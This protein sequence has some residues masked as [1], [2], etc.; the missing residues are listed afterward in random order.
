MG[1]EEK[2]QQRLLTENKG[3]GGADSGMNKYIYDVSKLIKD[4]SKLYQKAMVDLDKLRQD[5]EMED[6]LRRASTILATSFDKPYKDVYAKLE[7]MTGFFTRDSTAMENITTKIQQAFDT[8][9][10]NLEKAI[11]DLTNE[12][13]REMLKGFGV[14]YGR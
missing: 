7:D 14:I 3:S 4:R 6:F 11:E 9:K 8:E 10:Q 13:N 12:D 5:G 1:Q 2:L